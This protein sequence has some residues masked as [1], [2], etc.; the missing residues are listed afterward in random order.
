MNPVQLSV[1]T[2]AG[3]IEVGDGAADDLILDLGHD[4]VQPAHES[5]NRA[6]DG[7]GRQ[8]N[9]LWAPAQ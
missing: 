4:P 5:D 1:Y 9:P 2:G 8:G 7:A 3:L 6:L